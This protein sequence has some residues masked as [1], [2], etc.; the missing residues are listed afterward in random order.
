[1]QIPTSTLTVQPERLTA[2]KIDPGGQW[3]AMR[4]GRRG[5]SGT[6]GAQ[7]SATYT[8]CDHL[9]G[10]N[11]T[12][13]ASLESTVCEGMPATSGNGGGRAG[14][15][16]AFPDHQEHPR[17]GGIHLLRRE[18]RR[19]ADDNRVFVDRSATRHVHALSTS[20]AIEPG[21][22]TRHGCRSKSRERRPSLRLRSLVNGPRP[23]PATGRQFS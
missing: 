15:E 19:Q 2:P 6:C 22:H 23:G 10:P 14:K 17:S 4:Y 8:L 9:D 11:P 1:M 5:G 13:T 16:W 18:R 3:W 12:L 20:V 21:D 7:K